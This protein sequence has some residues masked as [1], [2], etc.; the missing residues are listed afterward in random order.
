MEMMI[1]PNVHV[2]LLR[3]HFDLLFTLPNQDEVV[4]MEAAVAEAETAVKIVQI[5]IC[6]ETISEAEAFLFM[7][8]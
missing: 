7:M 6:K 1:F 2:N 5:T 4:R 8:V 3:C